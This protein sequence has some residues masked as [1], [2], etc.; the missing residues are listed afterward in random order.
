MRALILNGEV[1]P[2]RTVQAVH[3]TAS[4]YFKGR[5]WEVESL[6]LRKMKIAPCIGCFGCWLKTPGIC[7]I[8]D[9]GREVVK[10]IIGSDLLVLLT[11]VTFG[12]YSSELKKALDRIIPLISPYFMKMNG[13]THHRPRYEKFPDYFGLGVLP[14]RDAESERIF[15]TLVHRNAINT[16]SKTYAAAVI[17]EDEE[18]GK[19]ES[20][21]RGLFSRMEVAQ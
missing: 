14:S 5:N 10:E 6:A 16:H 9:A 17:T 1:A 2:N 12:G 4:D 11:P 13:E 21:A 15:R 7:V 18:K 19:I 8:N 20:S 3:E